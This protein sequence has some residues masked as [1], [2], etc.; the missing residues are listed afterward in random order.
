MRRIGFVLFFLLLACR[1][2]TPGGAPSPANPTQSSAGPAIQGPQGAL[3][4][5]PLPKAVP[6]A[7]AAPAYQVR[8]HPDGPLYVGDLLSLEVIPPPGADLGG[9][10]L[11][12]EVNGAAQT[13]SQR[14]DFDEYGIGR[15][16]QA[17]LPWF[18]DT[19]GLQPGIYELRFSI[20]PSG[21]QWTQNLNLLPAEQ[22][23]PPEP[24]AAWAIAESDCC[25]VYYITGSEA[26]RDLPALLQKLDDQAASATQR[27]G[28]SLEAPVP[29]TFLPRV[30]GHG[31]FASGEIAVSY[32][33]RHY[34][35]SGFETV[36]HH[37][38]VHLL[39]S[40]LGGQLRPTLLVEGLA[41]YLTGGH[42]KPEQLRARA[43]ALLPPQPGCT[44]LHLSDAAQNAAPASEPCGLDWYIPLAE[45]VDQFYFAQHEIGYLQAGALVEYMVETFGWQA[46]STFYRDIR[47]L[48]AQDGRTLDYTQSAALEQA[49]LEH[50]DLSLEEL[51]ADFVQWLEEADVTPGLSAD[52]RLSVLFYETVRRYQQELDPS[53]Y[54]LT[55][56]LPDS[57]QMRERG[58]VADLLRRP[59]TPYNRA[60]EHLLVHADGA[61]RGGDYA[62]TERL[63]KVVNIVLDR[64]SVQN[65]SMGN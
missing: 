38:M 40:R 56:W 43:A 18:W 44:P 19:D 13:I 62:R 54:F 1:A 12:I 14:V 33:D 21:E 60:L 24:E 46:Y 9:Q 20:Q 65:V 55:A 17:T 3:V 6:P 5:T 22:T 39:D 31:G 2:F 61:L 26:Q 51:D 25:I 45:M 58:I 23:P 36:V 34:A 53:A 16:I 57:K 27:M 29:I 35:G 28:V 41:V 63:L 48:S 4:A 64:L 32:L 52:V 49:L 7:Q 8:L 10:S 50:F 47:P 30:L 37:E 11:Q 15:R 59:S 42:F